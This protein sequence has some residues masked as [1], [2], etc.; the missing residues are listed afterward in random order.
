MSKV[1]YIKDENFNLDINANE[2]YEI[3]HYVI[4]KSV[5]VVINLKGLN[6]KVVYHYSTINFDDNTFK[7]TINHLCSNTISEIYNHGVNV[8]FKKLVFDVT[9]YV[10]KDSFKCF[11]NQENQIINLTNGISQILPNLLINNYDTFSNHAAYIGKFKEDI[12]FYLMS[13]GINEQ[14]ATRLLMKSL[15][16]NGGNINEKVTDLFLKKLMEV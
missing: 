13:R 14:I 12:L 11:C 8:S 6:A 10:P 1:L 15:L 3:Y 4:N 16:L 2:T 5:N 9:G 7:I